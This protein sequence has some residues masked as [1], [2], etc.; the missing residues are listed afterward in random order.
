MV[1]SLPPLAHAGQVCIKRIQENPLSRLSKGWR[2]LDLASSPVR[3]DVLIDPPARP[4]T[5]GAWA[6]GAW[7]NGASRSQAT[8]YLAPRFASFP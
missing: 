3:L 8:H 5:W 4:W 6:N 2:I 1:K 7:A